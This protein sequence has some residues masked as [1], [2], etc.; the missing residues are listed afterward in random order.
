M[1]LLSFI[2]PPWTAAHTAL[3]N[4]WGRSYFCGSALLFCSLCIQHWLLMNYSLLPIY[5][6]WSQSG[7]AA[8]C[9]GLMRFQILPWVHLRSDLASFV[10]AETAQFL[11][12]TSFITIQRNKWVEFE[13]CYKDQSTCFICSCWLIKENFQWWYSWSSWINCII[14]YWNPPILENWILNFIIN[15]EFHT[16]VYLNS[17]L[18]NWILHSVINSAFYTGIYLKIFLISKDNTNI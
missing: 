17:I 3:V 10:I 6:S 1:Q 16:G 12:N 13:S 8:A 5:P 9:P 11:R 18:G 14:L 4:P 15:S 7:P 2:F